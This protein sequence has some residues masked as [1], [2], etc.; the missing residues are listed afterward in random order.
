MTDDAAFA[1]FALQAARDAGDAILPHF[2]RSID[3]EDKGGTRGYDPAKA[4]STEA[5][6]EIRATRG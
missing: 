5:R 3:I 1:D 6:R 2:R 4:K